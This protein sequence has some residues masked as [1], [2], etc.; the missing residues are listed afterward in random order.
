MRSRCEQIL[1][2]EE[3]SHTCKLIASANIEIDFIFSNS[4]FGGI[5][6]HSGAKVLPDDFWDKS[7]KFRKIELSINSI[8]LLNVNN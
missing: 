7:K 4:H 6:C 1:I 2:R 5:N 8:R 3:A